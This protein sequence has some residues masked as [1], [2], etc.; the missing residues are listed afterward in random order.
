MRDHFISHVIIVWRQSYQDRLFCST[1]TLHFSVLFNSYLDSKRSNCEKELSFF[2][3]DRVVYG[4]SG[5]RS[6]TR[7]FN[8]SIQTPDRVGKQRGNARCM[9]SVPNTVKV[10]HTGFQTFPA[11][12]QLKAW[13]AAIF[14][15]DL[16][17]RKVVAQ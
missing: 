5:K 9:N 13:L 16:F 12:R 2:C 17:R 4:S 10:A 7:V 3:G 8:S 6:V 15:S 11:L 14:D 1:G